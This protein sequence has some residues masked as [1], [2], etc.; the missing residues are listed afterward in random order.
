M[1]GSSKSTVSNEISNFTLNRSRLDAFNSQTNSM[2]T[3]NIMNSSSSCSASSTQS[4]DNEMGDITVI[5]KNQKAN[6]GVNT[7]QDNKVNLQCIQ[8]TVQQ[9]DISSTMAQSILE[10]MKQSVSNDTMTKL[11]NSAE[12]S[13]SAGAGG[14]ILNPFSSSSSEINMKLSNTQIT[15][16]ERKLTNLVS[17]TVA[18]T[19]KA[20]DIK[21]CFTKSIQLQSTKVG[22][23]KLIGEGNEFNFNISTKQIGQTLATCQQLTEQTSQVTSQLSAALGITIVDDTKSANTTEAQNTAK[24]ETKVAGFDAIIDS[25]FGGLKGVVGLYVGAIA[26]VI[27]CCSCIIGLIFIIPALKGSNKDSEK[28]NDTNTNNST[29]ESADAP[30]SEESAST[31]NSTDESADAP[32]SEE[33]AT[34]TDDSASNN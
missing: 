2:I 24:A 31:N 21:D 8:K 20:T 19:V 32:A 15:D 18:N 25:I 29:D 11:V 1:G 14:G 17:N 6:I 34:T 9:M 10:N 22:N 33:S 28:E 3:E 5:G 4:S 16:T 30:A 12:A 23:I 7:S 26:L 27:I 13:M